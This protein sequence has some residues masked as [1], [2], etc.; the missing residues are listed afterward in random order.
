MHPRKEVLSIHDLPKNEISYFL[1]V[2]ISMLS[3]PLIVSIVTTTP[4]CTGSV[5]ILHSVTALI[6]AIHDVGDSPTLHNQPLYANF[7]LE[8]QDTF[9]LNVSILTYFFL[10]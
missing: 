8:P 3:R 1:G 2:S 7:L 10:L 4:I 6:W 9:L 5:D